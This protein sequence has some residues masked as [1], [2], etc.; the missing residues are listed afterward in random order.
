[1]IKL[2]LSNRIKDIEIKFN[3]SVKDLLYQMHW[4][5]DMKHRDIALALNMPRPT[6]TRWF[7]RLDLPIQSC[8]RF[9]DK[10]LTSWLYKTGKLKKKVYNGSD[11]KIQ[12]NRINVGFFKKWSSEMAYVLGFFAADGC[13]YINPRGSR[14]FCF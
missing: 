3:A 11:R 10:N 4:S 2:E 6:L 5:E 1:M 8:R 13:M 9:T 12:R 14:Y 7:H